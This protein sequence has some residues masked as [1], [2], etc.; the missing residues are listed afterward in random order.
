MKKLVCIF[1]LLTIAL[2][3]FNCGESHPKLGIEKII[4]VEPHHATRVLVVYKDKNGRYYT[5]TIHQSNSITDGTITINPHDYL[6]GYGGKKSY[7]P[8][9]GC[10]QE[11]QSI[12]H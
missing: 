8:L 4:A 7:G 6:A 1:T 2:V 12:S 5:D 3:L 9:P 11:Y 10:E